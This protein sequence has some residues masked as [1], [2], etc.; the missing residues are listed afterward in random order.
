MF[1]FQNALY[2]DG[3]TCVSDACKACSVLMTQRLTQLNALNNKPAREILYNLGV[4]DAANVGGC[5]I[6]LARNFGGADALTK[7]DVSHLRYKPMRELESAFRPIGE[8]IY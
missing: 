5:L 7:T 2:H 1:L 8:L 4:T 6:L 3:K